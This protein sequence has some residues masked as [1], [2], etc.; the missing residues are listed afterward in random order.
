ME[1]VAPEHDFEKSSEEYVANA[2]CCD[3]EEADLNRI[4]GL[5]VGSME[6]VL[7]D[8]VAHRLVEKKGTQL[9]MTPLARVMAEHFI[10]M[11]RL[12]EVVRLTKVMDDPLEIIA[13][14][15]SEDVHKEKKA[16]PKKSGQ[17][18]KESGPP[19]NGRKRR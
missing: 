15:E 8:L 3:G 13:E 5:M 18:P 16:N 19:R 12:L 17:K 7:P 2:I 6:P 9:V 1:E 14:L 11:E 10:G 4:N